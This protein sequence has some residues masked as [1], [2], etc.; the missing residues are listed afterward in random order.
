MLEE[1]EEVHT[2]LGP[3][4][5]A[6]KDFDQRLGTLVMG[7]SLFLLKQRFPIAIQRVIVSSIRDQ[8]CREEGL[9]KIFHIE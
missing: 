4:R 7:G 1:R 5:K 2:I 8:L 9:E 3:W 6:T